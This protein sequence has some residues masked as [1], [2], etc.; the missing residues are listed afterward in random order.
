MCLVHGTSTD[1][2]T[3]NWKCVGSIDGLSY[4]KSIEFLDNGIHLEAQL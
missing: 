3:I 2:T 1:R 4:T